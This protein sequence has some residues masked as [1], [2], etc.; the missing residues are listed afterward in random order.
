M[1]TDTRKFTTAADSNGSLDDASLVVPDKCCLGQYILR[2]YLRLL[3]RN[4]SLK[5]KKK[6]DSQLNLCLG[7]FEFA[8]GFEAI[9]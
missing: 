6:S 7:L 5:I 4:R 3:L 8:Q 9:E 1:I 2:T